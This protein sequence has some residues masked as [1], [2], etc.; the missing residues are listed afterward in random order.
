[1]DRT[2]VCGTRNPGSIP[3]EGTHSTQNRELLLGFVLFALTVHSRIRPT[4]AIY[5]RQALLNAPRAVVSR[6]DRRCRQYT[7]QE[8]VK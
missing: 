5:G 1:M 3:G 8:S 2:R 6:R 7:P 4:Q